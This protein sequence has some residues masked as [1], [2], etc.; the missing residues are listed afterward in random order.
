MSRT[1]RELAYE[2]QHSTPQDRDAYETL[3]EQARA[4]I[5]KDHAETLAHSI[6]EKDATEAVKRLIGEFVTGHQLHISGLSIQQLADRLY[7]DMVGFGFLD[8]YITDPDIEEINGNSWR[9]IEI[10]IPFA[11]VLAFGAVG[12]VVIGYL[13][14]LFQI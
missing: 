2:R 9:D 14:A 13:Y 3:L 5:S 7:G 12:A 10:V 1:F 11:P 8:K 4:S 6:T